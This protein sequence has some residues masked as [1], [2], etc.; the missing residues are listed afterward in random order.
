[1]NVTTAAVSAAVRR[2]TVAWTDPSAA[3]DQPKLRTF[4]EPLGNAAA[5]IPDKSARG[6]ELYSI[7]SEREQTSHARRVE[8]TQPATDTAMISHQPRAK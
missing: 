7:N 2:V 6:L 1:M 4:K 5:S 3:G 8:S